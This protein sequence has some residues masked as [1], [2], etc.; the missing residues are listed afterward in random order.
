MTVMSLKVSFFSMNSNKSINKFKSAVAMLY[1][2]DESSLAFE[3]YTLIEIKIS[4]L[5]K[6]QIDLK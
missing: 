1:Q 4:L 2:L 5:T 3:A 6:S